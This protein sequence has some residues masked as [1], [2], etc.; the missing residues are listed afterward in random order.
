MGLI[1]TLILVFFIYLQSITNFGI[2]VMKTTLCLNVAAQ[3]AKNQNNHNFHFLFYM[4]G[5][6]N[7]KKS[8]SN[9]LYL[10]IA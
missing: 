10:V 8:L 6:S 7:F 4:L 2:I 3:T 5:K 1:Q 9:C